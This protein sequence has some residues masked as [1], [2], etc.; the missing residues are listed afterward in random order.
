MSTEP[1]L[2]SETDCLYLRAESELRPIHWTFVVQLAPDEDPLSFDEVVRRV[3]ARSGEREIYRLHLAKKVQRRPRFVPASSW[4]PRDHVH[5]VE[6][7]DEAAVNRWISNAVASHLPTDRPLWEIAL[8]NQK[9]GGRQYLALRVHHCITDGMAGLAFV[10]LLADTPSDTTAEF[11]RFI[12]SRRFALAPIPWRERMRIIVAA[13]RMLLARG[14]KL[15]SDEGRSAGREVATLSLSTGDFRRRAREYGASTNEFVLSAVAAA[16]NASRLEAGIAKDALRVQLPVT[17]DRD[18]RHTGNA[19]SIAVLT[20]AGDV[21]DVATHVARVKAELRR[22]A[23]SDDARNAIIATAPIKYL[24]WRLQRRLTAKSLEDLCD[25]S[26]G[27]NPG[28]SA[29][30]TVLGRHVSRATPFVPIVDYPVSVTTLMYRD[31][32]TLGIVAD[33]VEFPGDLGKFL[34][35]L[36]DLIGAESEPTETESDLVAGQIGESR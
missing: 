28:F 34:A 26:V 8:L 33:P 25:V 5:S 14:L 31:R 23:E 1:I 12:S 10:G 7:A 24:P 3:V 15:R 17:L 21:T 30:E 2:L 22:A 27:V 20:V 35:R 36:A 13:N 4:D 16:L 29:T 19:A 11:D 32:F 18:I 9:Q 6:L